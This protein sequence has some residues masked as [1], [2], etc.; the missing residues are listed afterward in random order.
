MFYGRAFKFTKKASFAIFMASTML[1][2]SCQEALQASKS[3]TREDAISGDFYYTG[4]GYV[5][6][7]NP[8]ISSGYSSLSYPNM[9]D[10]VS[11][12]YVTELPYLETPCYFKFGQT[13]ED[14]FKVLNNTSTSIPLQ[15]NNGGWDYTVGSDEFYQVNTFYHVN[16]MLKRFYQALEGAHATAHTYGQNLVPPAAKYDIENTLSF[17][18][19]KGLRDPNDYDN[20]LGVTNS[21]LN[22]YSK[23]Y[24][25]PFNAYYSPSENKLCLGWNDTNSFLYAAQDPSVIYHELGHVLVKVMMNQRN[26]SY[27]MPSYHATPFQS[28]LGSLFYD[29]AGAINEGVADWFSYFVN[30]RTH[31][32]EWALGRF[33]NASRALTEDD[34]IHDGRVSKSSGERLAYP[35]Y[36]HYDP[37][38]PDSSTEDIHYAGQIISHYLTS[39]TEDLKTTCSA[40]HEE[41]GDMV[42]TVLNETFAEVGDMSAKGSD[43][44]DQFIRSEDVNLGAFFTNM[45]N[46]QAYLWGHQVNP[47]NFR[48]FSQIL[49]KNINYN[50]TNKSCSQFTKDKSEKLLD[51]YGLL[52]FKNYGENKKGVMFT[53]L[54]G[55]NIQKTDTTYADAFSDMFTNCSTNHF[56]YPVDNYCPLGTNTLVNESNRRNSVL[57]AKEFLEYPD[58]RDGVS[59]AYI[60][61]ERGPIETL[62][63]NLLYEGS[64]VQTSEGTAGV[65]Y[66]NNNIKISPGEIV[67]I[68]INMF[69]NSNSTMG[70]VQILAN[71]WD[72]MKL[73][74]PSKT[75]VN[76]VENRNDAKDIANWSPC[77]IDG[78]PGV[79]ENGV[80]SDGDT[81]EG[82]CDYVTRDNF[83]VELDGTNNQKYNLDASQPICLVQNSSENETLWVSQDFHRRTELGLEASQCLNP[84]AYSGDDFNPNE[85]LI[86]FLPGA[87]QAVLGKINP[88]KSW[89]QTL[90]DDSVSGLTIQ[91][92]AITL[93]EVNKRIRPGTTFNCRLRARFTNC[94]DCF[95]DA[96]SGEEYA[97]YEMAGAKPFKVINFKFTVVD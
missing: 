89:A 24:L 51:E 67:G 37:N 27:N 42:L 54:G 75:Y 13:N 92:N 21:T 20:I 48:K 14:C 90:T 39:L 47:T 29:E 56:I 59:P 72:H 93:M 49:A 85:C 30:G 31:F 60:V 53:D 83:V 82:N 40:S 15:A 57:I 26:I 97:D 81:T 79:D 80:A 73:D 70:G 66:N 1:L 22:V 46:Q 52:L 7:S 34:P 88:Q 9:S 96:D 50:I 58:N 18:L 77:Q 3:G 32:G 44:F 65:E 4:N 69:N 91:Q 33:F 63:A 87:D 19:A 78:W 35:E 64:P 28:E 68:N 94:S 62:L 95:E 84:P 61:D 5:Y 45:N 71:D 41:A 11:A 8:I 76:R 6:E 17:W 38:D 2:S 86:R 36:L 55:G 74:D 23:C 12:T 10:Y 16:K 43:V 25:D